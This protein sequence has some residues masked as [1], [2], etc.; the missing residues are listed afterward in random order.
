MNDRLKTAF[1]RWSIRQFIRLKWR[2]HRATDLSVVNER[3]PVEGGRIG[4][5]L[6]RPRGAGPFP[7]LHFFHGGGWVRGDL[8]THDALCRDLCVQSGRLVVAFDYRLA[9]E[10]PFPSAVHD[11]LA[12]LAWIREHA[13]RLRGDSQRLAICGDSSGG[14]LAAIA[15]QQARTLQ[16]GLIQAQVLIYPALDYCAA[17]QWPSY[18]TY[19][20]AP[21]ALTL[22]RMKHLWSLYLRKGPAW[23]RTDRTCELMTPL[24][25]PDLSGLPPT[26]LIIA[27]HDVLHDEGMAY[28]RR[29]REA[30][31]DV[32]AKVYP[33][34]QHGFVGVMPS[35]AHR[36]AVADIAAWLRKLD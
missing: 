2:G 26:L 31:N 27:E 18:Q 10:H 32:E 29:L 19:G 36:A 5:R 4:V 35:A 17:A 23:N 15:A 30:G 25:T 6:Y 24:H 33:A 7:I 21:Y 13:A 11:C 8:E 14:N 3:M 20:S 9:P 1:E 12:S 22:D 16:P 28:G 34:Q